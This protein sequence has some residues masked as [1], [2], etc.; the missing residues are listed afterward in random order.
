MI[1]ARLSFSRRSVFKLFLYKRKR[2]AGVSNSSGACEERFRKA[3][4]S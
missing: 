1:I 3:P 2:K 4:F